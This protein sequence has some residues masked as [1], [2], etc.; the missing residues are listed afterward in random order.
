MLQ[1]ED[2][3]KVH[4]SGPSAILALDG[5]TLSVRAGEFV[6]LLGASGCGKSTL[7]DLVAG[8][9][10]PT[11]GLLRSEAGSALM[12][13]ESALFPWLTVKRNVELPLQLHGVPAPQRRERVTELLDLVRLSE[14]AAKRPHELS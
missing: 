8:L 9:E 14:F 2:V 7:L 13:Q 1:L 5:V 3:T 12:F 10:E 11:G 4:G 6:C